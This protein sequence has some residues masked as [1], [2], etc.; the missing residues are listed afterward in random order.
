MDIF[1]LSRYKYVN[2]D[3]RNILA[4]IDVCSRKAFA[5]PL[6]INDGH[7]FKEA[8]IKMTKFTKPRCIISDHDAAFVK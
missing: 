7:T 6:I 5:I 4:A 1:D 3:N 8:F 2:K